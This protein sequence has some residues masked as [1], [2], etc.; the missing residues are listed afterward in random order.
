MSSNAREQVSAVSAGDRE[1]GKEIQRGK[2]RLKKHFVAEKANTGAESANSTLIINQS[3]Q[4][5]KHATLMTMS[6]RNQGPN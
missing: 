2:L 1:Q 5:N 6:P 4:K 3:N